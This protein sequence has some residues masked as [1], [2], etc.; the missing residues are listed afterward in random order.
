MA[1]LTLK[2]IIAAI[3]G[4]VVQGDAEPSIAGIAIDSR[5]I[6]PGELFIALIGER[7]DGHN[8]LAQAAA[9]GA[10]AL[11]VMKTTDLPADCGPVIQVEDTLKALGMIARLYRRKFDIPVIAITGSNGKTTTKDL[12]AAVLSEQWSII[13]T[14][15]NFNNEIGLPLTLLQIKAETQ[16]AVVEMGMRGAG[17]I[18]QL[19]AIAEPSIG[20]VT[21]V[22]LSHLELLGSQENIALAK[23]ELDEALPPTGLAVLNGDDPLVR[24]MQELHRGKTVLYGIEGLRLDYRADDLKIGPQGSTFTVHFKGGH[25][26]VQLPIAGRHNVLNALA[27]IAVARECGISSE[28]IQ[29]GLAQP[30]LTAK[31]LNII[32]RNGIAIIDDTY[33]AS[34]ASVKAA[35]DVL[36]ISGMGRRKIAV[37]ADMLELGPTAAQIHR[38]IGEYAARTGVDRMLSFGDLALGYSEGFN[39]VAAGKSEHYLE[40][41]ALIDRL[42]SLIQP[43]D[44]ILIKGSRGMKMDEVVAA[45]SE[46]E[47]GD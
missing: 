1:S 3:D 27:A 33:N 34:P 18:R 5:K 22:G 19:A 15:A 24:K 39:R 2:E 30:Q 26:A 6:Q 29:K 31:R 9:A 36:K 47:V 7:F 45:L 14:E 38:E 16:A 17:Q 25:S 8:F 12:V 35:L 10:A 4:K 28:M 11:V 46:M 37:L 40:K 41:Q 44:L 42:Q 43:N 23:S 20:V 21:N 13:K 32:E